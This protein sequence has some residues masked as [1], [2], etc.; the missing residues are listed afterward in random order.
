MNAS[1]EKIL[2]PAGR[3]LLA[4]IFITSGFAK[5][6]DLPGTAGYIAS[7]GLP[8]AGFLAL[9]AGLL[10]LGAGLALALGFQVRWAALAL[11]LF[12]L[13]AAVLFHAYWSAPAEQAYV[14]QLMFMKNLAI[15]GGLFLASAFGAGSLSLDARLARG[16]RHAHA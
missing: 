6:S 11:G 7:A 3:I 2:V 4:L 13:A 10:E 8:L 9:G 16:A 12:T 5:L 1:L 15:A 14:Q